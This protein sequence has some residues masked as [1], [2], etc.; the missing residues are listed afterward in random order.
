MSNAFLH[1]DDDI[2]STTDGTSSGD[3]G[4]FDLI[5]DEASRLSLSSSIIRWP[6]DLA[7]ING[8]SSIKN[9]VTLT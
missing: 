5:Y 4:N 2:V 9:P 1:D 6:V 8:L 3:A 7:G